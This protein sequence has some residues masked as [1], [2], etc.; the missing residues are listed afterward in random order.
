RDVT[1]GN[2]ESRSRWFTYAATTLAT[3]V[4]TGGTGAAPRAGTTAAKQG[5][6]P[7]VKKPNRLNIN[8][9]FEPKPALN[10][11]N[12]DIPYNVY[13]ENWITN[14]TFQFAKKFDDGKNKI[15]PHAKGDLTK[16][17]VKTAKDFEKSLVKL[18]PAERVAAVKTKSQEVAKNAGLVKDSKLSK[19][20]GRDVY[21][22]PKTRELYSVDTQHGRFEKT[23]KKGKHEGEFDF[24]FMPTKPADSSGGHDLRVN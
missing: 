19:I 6:K 9:P 7:S 3:T 14:Q 23:N 11:G 18:P 21:K 13:N 15:R 24:D 1:N 4:G 8:N 2:A 12:V 17:M 5:T 10:A 16:G 22:D 20:N